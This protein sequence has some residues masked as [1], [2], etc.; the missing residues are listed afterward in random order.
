MAKCLERRDQNDNV[1][2]NPLTSIVLAVSD[3]DGIPEHESSLK[4]HPE[5]LRTTFVTSSILAPT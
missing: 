1:I 5:H 3:A 4:N 2:K